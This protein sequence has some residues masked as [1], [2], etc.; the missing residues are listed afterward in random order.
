MATGTICHEMTH[1]FG[2]PDHSWDFT[3]R[4]A[5][6]AKGGSGMQTDVMSAQNCWYAKQTAADSF[7]GSGPITAC[8]GRTSSAGSTAPRSRA[9]ATRTS[10]RVNTTTFTLFSGNE[11][12]L[13]RLNCIQFLDIWVE[14]DVKTDKGDNVFYDDSTPAWAGLD[15]LHGSGVV[16]HQKGT[17]PSGN[18]VPFVLVPDLANNPDQEFWS[19][20]RSARGS[21]RTPGVEVYVWVRSV[22]LVEGAPW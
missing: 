14:L 22:D 1:Q 3:T 12:V 2:E 6:G 11:P 17:V 15:R 21:E 9:S 8:S 16:I 7:S 5:G 19:A 10:T 4:V 18:T 13:E 20:G